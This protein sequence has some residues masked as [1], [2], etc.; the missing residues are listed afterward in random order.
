MAMEGLIFGFVGVTK[1]RNCF[2]IGLAVFGFLL[3]GFVF[4]VM[5]VTGLLI[6]DKSR[7]AAVKEDYHPDNP[8]P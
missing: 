2:L 1:A 6:I 5:G 3:N 8:N 4:C 7:P